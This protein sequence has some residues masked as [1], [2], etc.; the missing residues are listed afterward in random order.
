MLA[1]H[2]TPLLP[3]R[4]E[5][6]HLGKSVKQTKFHGAIYV[7]ISS[8]HASPPKKNPLMSSFSHSSS[9]SLHFLPSSGLRPSYPPSQR[10]SSCFLSFAGGTHRPAGRCPIPLSNFQMCSLER[11]TCAPASGDPLTSFPPDACQTFIL[12]Q[13]QCGH[14]RD[15]WQPPERDPAADAALLNLLIV[16]FITH[17]EQLGR[18]DLGHPWGS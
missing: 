7:L 6:K 15:G 3:S 12:P 13:S 9:I 8:N 10:I 4:A 18:G 14:C 11:R 17:K 5:S 2:I 16:S 1:G